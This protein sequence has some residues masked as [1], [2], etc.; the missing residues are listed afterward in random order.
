MSELK[1]R[2]PPDIFEMLELKPLLGEALNV[3]AEAPTPK[4]TF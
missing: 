1:L 4:R 2:P 3:G